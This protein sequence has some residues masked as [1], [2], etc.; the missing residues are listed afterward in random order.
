MKKWKTSSRV[1]VML[2]LSMSSSSSFVVYIVDIGERT[3]QPPDVFLG[4]SLLAIKNS[5]ISM[6]ALVVCMCDAAFK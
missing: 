5:N 1:L 2:L 4:F 6:M 3:Q